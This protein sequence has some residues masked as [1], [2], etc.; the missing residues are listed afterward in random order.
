MTRPSESELL[1]Q[2]LDAIRAEKAP[3]IKRLNDL[4][5]Q[6]ERINYALGIMREVLDEVCGPLKPFDQDKATGIAGAG[7]PSGPRQTLEQIILGVFSDRT[8]LTS[9]EVADI[10]EANSPTAVK[11]E[12]TLSTLSRMAGKELIRREGRLYFLVK[13]GEG[14][15]VGT[16]EPSDATKSVAGQP[17]A[18]ALT[19]EEGGDL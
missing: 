2:H 8:G 9:G 12:S 7:A 10:V 16:P 14:P 6:E 15:E 19:G 18:G 13:K 17:T 3:L 5:A 4:Q 1:N 11:R